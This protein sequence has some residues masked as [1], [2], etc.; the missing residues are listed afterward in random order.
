MSDRF[1]N[2]SIGLL[3][4]IMAEYHRSRHANVLPVIPTMTHIPDGSAE[5]N[6]VL[7][8]DGEPGTQCME[9]QLANINAVNDDFP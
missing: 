7:K 9:W 8:D 3:S 1:I 4:V 5:Q 6:R 2:L